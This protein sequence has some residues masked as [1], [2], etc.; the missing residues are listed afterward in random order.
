MRKALISAMILS[1]GLFASPAV[2]VDQVVIDHPAPVVPVPPEH[3]EV[4]VEHHGSDCQMTTVRK[5]NNEGDLKTVQ[6]TDCD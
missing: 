4:V 2:L 3:H 6:K 1:G 5:E